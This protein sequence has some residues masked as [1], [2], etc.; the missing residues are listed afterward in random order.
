MQTST[1]SLQHYTSLLAS[2]APAW[3]GSNCPRHSTQYV[4]SI[5]AVQLAMLAKLAVAACSLQPHNSFPGVAKAQS[6]INMSTLARDCNVCLRTTL[7][8]PASLAVRLLLHIWAPSQPTGSAYHPTGSE[9][10]PAA[11]TYPTQAANATKRACM[12]PWQVTAGHN[13]RCTPFSHHRANTNA[14][15]TIPKF[16]SHLGTVAPDRLSLPRLKDHSSVQPLSATPRKQ[17]VPQSRHACSHD[18][19][20]D[21]SERCAAANNHPARKQQMPHSRHECSHDKA[22]DS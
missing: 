12:R 15:N 14:D 8:E 22:T 20:T 16:S 5:L 10:C 9:P 3:Q 6:D 4:A 13:S 7:Q 11:D 2:A 19:A 17:Q 21:S 18:N 1:A